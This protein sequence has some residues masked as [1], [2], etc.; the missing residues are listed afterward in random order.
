M[1]HRLLA[2]LAAIALAA[3]CASSDDEDKGGGDGPKFSEALA[4]EAMKTHSKLALAVYEDS[5]AAAEDLRDALHAFVASPSETTFAAAKAAW[6]AAREPYGQAEALRFSGGPIDDEDTGVDR[7]LAAWPLDD[8]YIDYVL[9][10]ILDENGEPVLDGDGNPTFTTEHVGIVNDTSITLDAATIESLNEKDGGENISV[11]Y[12]AIEFLLWGQDFEADGPGRRPYTDYVTGDD[13]TA[14]NQ[15]RRGAYLSLLGDLLVQHLEQ[16]VQAWKEGDPS[17]Y[18]AAFEALPAA[19]GLGRILTG[20]TILNGDGLADERLRLPLDSHDVDDEASRFSDNT[21]RDIVASTTSIRIFFQGSYT[22]T[23][24]T[25]VE[26]TGVYHVMHAID[27]HLAEHLLD[28]VEAA[29]DLAEKLRSPFDREI[30]A[31]NPEGNARVQALI[32]ALHH[33]EEMLVDLFTLFGLPA[34]S[35]Q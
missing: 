10:P 25:T 24:G 34:P 32:D 8:A 14:L 31:D 35:I 20:L 16:V 9:Q 22:R 23:D 11:G 18:R 4:V 2:A 28:H 5:L 27:D 1:I 6:L 7:L 30:A 15:D 19:E 33:Q 17:N 12:H 3:G 21:H 29:V 13:G 26:G